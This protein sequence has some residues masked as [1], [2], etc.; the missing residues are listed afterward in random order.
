MN[1]ATKSL[2]FLLVVGLFGCGAEQSS[3]DLSFQRALGIFRQASFS[4]QV[5]TE[6]YKEKYP[7]FDFKV[8]SLY[9]VAGSADPFL[10]KVEIN[11]ELSCVVEERATIAKPF[12]PKQT[13]YSVRSPKALGL[14]KGCSNGILGFDSPSQFGPGYR[15]LGRFDLTI[16]H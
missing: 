13:P 14:Q 1:L 10:Y 16:T 12:Q 6:K 15:S 7:G 9:R 2:N 3:S 11:N 8:S 4:V 5:I